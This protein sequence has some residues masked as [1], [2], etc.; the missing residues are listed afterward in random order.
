MVEQKFP[1]LKG[2][3]IADVILTTANTNVT[4]PELIVT[5]NV[6]KTGTANFY[7]VFYI[8]KDVPKNGD[9]V[10]LDQV[11][12]D[13]INAGFKTSDSDST[14]AK[15]IIDNLLKSNA[16]VSSNDKTYPISVVN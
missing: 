7:S 8:T 2:S 4:L 14:I 11:K 15:Y 10:N 5:K 1:F 9:D 6:G 13:L 16:D 3:Q 12:Q